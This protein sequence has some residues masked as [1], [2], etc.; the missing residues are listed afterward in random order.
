MSKKLF[1]L[2]GAVLALYSVSCTKQEMI[3]VDETP[4]QAAEA[5]VMLSATAAVPESSRVAL[6]EEATGLK[7][8]WEAGD[9]IFGFKSDGTPFDFEVQSV[10]PSSGAAT[11][12]QIG[13][14]TF[15]PGET[16]FAIYATGKTS[17]DLVGT[18]CSF[19]LS[20]QDQTAPPVVMSSSATVTEGPSVCF[21][22][23]NELS[24]VGVKD[25]M[26]SG[27]LSEGKQ[28]RKL[29]LSGQKIV[30]SF[31]LSLSGGE[32]VAE[33]DAPKNFILRDVRITPVESGENLT[34]EEPV[35][36]AVVPSGTIAKFTLQDN[37]GN[38]YEYAL[39]KAPER[40][41]YYRW[42]D[43]TL[44]TVALPEASG[45]EA[46]SVAWSKSN[47]GTDQ[48]SNMGY[49]FRWSD[50]KHL[51]DAA[52]TPK[53]AAG[54]ESIGF[55][56]EVGQCYCTDAAGNSGK[57][58]Y[59]KYLESG[60]VLEPVDDIVQLTYPCTGWRMPTVEE[61]QA[62]YALRNDT[63]GYKYTFGETDKV[64][65]RITNLSTSKELFLR[66][67]Q[68]I[69]SSGGTTYKTNQGRYWTS[70]ST[71]DNTKSYAAQYTQIVG[72]SGKTTG[73]MRFSISTRH[74]GY[75]VR[76]VKPVS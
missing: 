6:A 31:S 70:S 42:K 8:S 73:E 76:P 1:V 75:S 57:G 41:K 60:L 32:L 44:N 51:Y 62:L 7:S 40:G 19:D 2:A 66:A 28:V 17:A 72:A 34:F 23:Q 74:S 54:Y 16:I 21:T 3:P 61:F 26:F 39:N 49:V 18:K 71:D 37:K 5:A 52:S 45:I 33:Y 43:K 15:T 50:C 20:L 4:A 53:W 11:L 30:S 55:V 24:I 12:A 64:G 46:G 47:L 68:H 14:T 58:V 67:N 35:Y 38:F 59:S 10:D 29:V 63:D 22:F 65:I 56:P 69:F 48:P 27:A 36:I 13:S 9:R 25:P